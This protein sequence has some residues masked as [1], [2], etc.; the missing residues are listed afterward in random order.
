MIVEE[1]DKTPEKQYLGDI[2]KNGSSMLKKL[3]DKVRQF[4]SPAN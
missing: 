3:G 2:D 1:I 4:Q